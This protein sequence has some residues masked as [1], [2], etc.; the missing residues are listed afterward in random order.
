MPRVS[1]FFLCL[2]PRLTE[3]NKSW[4]WQRN[5]T[6][7]FS[8]CQLEWRG[9]MR[10][11]R[12]KREGR[13][14]R[15]SWKMEALRVW[16]SLREGWLRFVGVVENCRELD[17]DVERKAVR[18]CWWERLPAFIEDLEWMA[19]S[20]WVWL[21]YVVEWYEGVSVTA[22]GWWRVLGRLAVVIYMC[23]WLSLGCIYVE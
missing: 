23:W 5:E 20:I 8:Q 4:L 11:E 12:E 9:R 2:L 14:V 17:C 13:F 16:W 19:V 7:I 22:L 6:I 21:C 15:P 18:K 3:G 10:S 1:N